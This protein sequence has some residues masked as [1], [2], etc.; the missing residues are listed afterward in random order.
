M[1][2]EESKV[3]LAVGIGSIGPK[4]PF[5]VFCSKGLNN[6]FILLAPIKQ[7]AV[8]MKSIF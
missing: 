8:K 4:V 3:G 1:G 6:R 7:E 5:K 2:L